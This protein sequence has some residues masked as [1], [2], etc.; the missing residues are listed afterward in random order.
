MVDA[1][2]NVGGVAA[3]AGVASG[4]DGEVV[5]FYDFNEVVAG[6][7]AGED[8]EFGPG[9]QEDLSLGRPEDPELL[10]RRPLDGE[11]EAREAVDG[12]GGYLCE[13]DACDLPDREL[14]GVAE[15]GHREANPRPAH[16][17]VFSPA[18]KT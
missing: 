17:C 12:G 9:R 13:E 1:L 6:D 2:Y 8:P 14:V 15:P 4:V 18:L 10:R 3:R 11:D 16:L 7:V 5:L